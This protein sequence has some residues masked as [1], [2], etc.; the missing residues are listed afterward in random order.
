VTA[1]NSF[2]QSSYNAKIEWSVP[3]DN[4]S[5]KNKGGVKWW[6]W[7]LIVLA[8]LVVIGGGVFAFMKC[9]KSDV[10]PLLQI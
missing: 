5:S 2:I 7:L 3:N 9:R 8:I 4:S 1:Y 6:G 10:V